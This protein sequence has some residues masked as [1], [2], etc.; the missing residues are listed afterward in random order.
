MLA[1]VLKALHVFAAM[2]FLGGGLGSV[3][4]K[5][6]AYQGGDLGVI[7]FCD[8]EIVRADWLFTV[9]SGLTLPVTGIAIALLYGLPLTTPWILTGIV[10][11]A[12]AGL[13]WL[14][15]AFLQLRMRRLAA[16]ALASGAPLDP[17]YHAAHR[18]WMLLGVPSFTAALVVIWAMVAKGSLLPF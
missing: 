16:A 5:I 4:Y 17:A 7:A 9:P 11:W 3:Y 15:A 8:R 2:L 18:T 14:P 10:G 12:V 6:R 1:V 13:T